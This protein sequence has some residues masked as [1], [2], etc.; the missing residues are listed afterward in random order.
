MRSRAFPDIG[1]DDLFLDRAFG[2][3]GIEIGGTE[4]LVVHSPR[5]AHNLVNVLHRG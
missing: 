2:R 1:A 4:P 5:R 3:D